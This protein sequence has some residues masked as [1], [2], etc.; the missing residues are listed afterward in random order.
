MGQ[1]ASK[2]FK[3]IK[4]FVISGIKPSQRRRRNS[5]PVPAL[6]NGQEKRLTPNSGVELGRVRSAGFPACGF[7]GLSSPVFPFWNW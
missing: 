1:A 6:S 5:L 2:A 4:A 3:A 7:T